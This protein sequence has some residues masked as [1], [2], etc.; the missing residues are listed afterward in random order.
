MS[1]PTDIARAHAKAD[2]TRID[3]LRWRSNP[4]S[5]TLAASPAEPPAP[6]PTKA[7]ETR[8]DTLRWRS[9]PGSTTLAA[10]PAEPPAPFPTKADET[11]IN[12]LKC[13]STPGSTT[14]AASPAE[15]PA[16]F[17]TKAD[18]TRIN[19]LRWRSP[20]ASTTLAASPAEP[21]APFPTKADETR[22]NT[23]KW[24]SNPGSTTL[25]VAPT[26]SAGPS[27]GGRWH[28][29]TPPSARSKAGRSPD[30]HPWPGPEHAPT[31]PGGTGERRAGGP[32]TAGRVR[33]ACG[34]AAQRAG[35]VD[36]REP[37]GTGAR[38]RA[39]RD[40]AE[41]RVLRRANPRVDGRVRPDRKAGERVAQP[42][43]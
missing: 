7:D 17:P 4:G 43:Q 25:T 2:E 26:T 15:P 12:T 21:P 18:D 3:T 5:T 42:V 9:T 32:D 39:D 24:R 40:Q 10:S 1:S 11:R 31:G 6:F 13:R 29:D 20:P 27:E 37:V 28:I 8:I 38:G 36:L 22:I 34:A 33:A 35:R 19:T 30:R 14:L 23:L 16:L 41:R